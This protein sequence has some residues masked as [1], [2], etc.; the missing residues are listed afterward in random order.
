[1]PYLNN[2][3]PDDPNAVFLN[4]QNLYG[5][6]ARQDIATAYAP[7]GAA[8]EAMH[9]LPGAM[10]QT[11]WQGYQQ[12]RAM[13]LQQQQAQQQHDVNQQ[14]MGTRASEE[15]R[16]Q[17][18]FQQ[19]QALLAAP[20]PT[21]PANKAYLS[22]QS[23]AGQPGAQQMTPQ[24]Q[25]PQGQV[26]QGQVPPQSGIPGRTMGQAL[27]AAPLVQQ[28]QAQQQLDLNKKQL[29]INATSQDVI[30]KINN[31]TVYKNYLASKASAIVGK[32]TQS[33]VAAQQ[34]AAKYAEAQQQMNAQGGSMML[35]SFNEPTPQT[36]TMNDAIK[37]AQAMGLDPAESA[38]VV[39][40]VFQQNQSAAINENLQDQATHYADWE[41]KFNG[42]N[43]D[44]TKLDQLI[45]R[46]AAT[47]T[48]VAETSESKQALE[49]MKPIMAKYGYGALPDQIRSNVR[50]VSNLFN[51]Q[52]TR[53]QPLL[54]KALQEIRLNQARTL[55]DQGLKE[56][57]PLGH[58]KMIQKLQMLAPGGAFGGQQNPVFLPNAHPQANGM[59]Q[60]GGNGQPMNSLRNLPGAQPLAPTQQRQ[61]RPAR[62]SMPQAPSVYPS[63]G[64][65]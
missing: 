31:D 58:P 15:A 6:R 45:K 49:E 2:T 21:D 8:E 32:L 44:T 1:M 14:L 25:V 17:Q 55:N 40:Q 35:A 50:Y 57:A 39:G 11:G 24:G 34:Y 48:P 53:A 26:P 37:D 63:E 38:T 23:P 52:P 46:Y 13:G 9:A 51:D 16:T 28:Q 33:R 22:G 56:V 61:Q 3:D 62:N 43:N 4:Q 54:D 41:Q 65:M 12:G 20:D 5:D 10:A 59:M 27:A 60:A 30:N 47:T 64:G 36:Y 19:A 7:M 42:V 18:K 29:S